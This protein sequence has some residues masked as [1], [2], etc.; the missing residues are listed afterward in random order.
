MLTAK[1][2]LDMLIA[3]TIPQYGTSIA[4]YGFENQKNILFCAVSINHPG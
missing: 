1:L 2:N 3:K 4:C